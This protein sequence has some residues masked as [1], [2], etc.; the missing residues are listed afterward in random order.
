MSEHLTPVNYQTVRLARGKHH[1]PHE[2]VCVM[3]LASMLAGEPFSDQPLCVCPVIA[4]FLRTYNDAIDDGRRQDLYRYAAIAIGTRGSRS[5][6][7]ERIE[8]CLA[9]GEQTQAQRSW[10]QRRFAPVKAPRRPG[11]TAAAAGS[12]A[13]RTITRHTDDTHARA[14]AFI[15][16]LC[17]M[18]MAAT[19]DTGLTAT[20]ANA[21]PTMS[22]ARA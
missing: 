20:P 21:I 17:A 1:F 2:G 7:Q 22:E 9:W 10:L 19:V 11:P 16:Q 18:T 12:F 15:E 3:E 4:A 5:I 13:A 14:L 6:Q 8:R